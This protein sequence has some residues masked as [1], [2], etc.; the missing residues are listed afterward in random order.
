[1]ADDKIPEPKPNNAFQDGFLNND[2][3]IKAV[4]KINRTGKIKVKLIGAN[5]G[6]VLYDDEQIVIDLGPIFG[7]SET[8]FLIKNGELREAK[9][10]I[11]WL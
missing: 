9:V 6:K 4:K 10:P 5:D 2:V 3:A 7:V 8:V 11:L 1:M